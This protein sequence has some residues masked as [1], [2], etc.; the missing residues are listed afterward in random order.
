MRI[1]LTGATGMVG[2]NI[3]EHTNS[4]KY[5]FISPSRDMLDLLSFE[6]TNTYLEK[7]KPDLIIHAAGLVGG[8]QANL[9]YSSDF[10]VKNTDMGRNIVIAAKNNKVPKLINL[11]SSCMY[12]RNAHN[13]LKEEYILKG[14]LEPTNEGYA[15]AKIYTAKLCEYISRENNYYQ[16][17]TIIPCN[18]YGKY[19]K[20]D[21]E[22]SHMVP[23][24]IKKVYDAKLQNNKKIDVWGS[25]EARREFMYA[26]DLADFLFYSINKFDLLPQYINV[27]LGKDYTI[28]EYYKIIAEVVGLNDVEFDHDLSKPEGMKQKLIDDTE[29]GKF[30]W[31]HSTSLK[32]GIT[33]T[34]NYYKKI[35]SNE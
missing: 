29:L 25:G 3:L 11:G 10:M 16:Y 26:G 17:K 34:L 12:P 20:F 6:S 28:N 2:S 7:I 31:Q 24:V 21:P 30:G 32:D 22:F 18:L 1:L 5:E 9:K 33:E 15:I 27:G 19:D 14:E 8:I 35:T 13:P 4:G 23:A